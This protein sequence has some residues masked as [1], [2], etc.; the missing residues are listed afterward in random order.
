VLPH[1]LSIETVQQV[2]V[3]AAPFDVRLGSFAGGLVNVVTKSGSNE[4]HGAVFGFV[5]D[6]R[7]VARNVARQRTDFTTRQFGG[8]VSGPIVRDRVHFF[9]NAD[10]QRRVVPDAG[11]FVTDTLGGVRQ[12]RVSYGNALRFQN[13]LSGYGVDGGSLGP[14]DGQLPA[15]DLFGKITLQLGSKSRVELS[16]RLAHADRRDFMDVGQRFDTTAL[17]SVA[18]LSRSSARTSRLIWNAL[19]GN[20]AQNEVI[21]SY[22]R[23]F[24]SCRPNGVLPRIQVAVDSGFLIAGP[25]SVCPTTAVDQS[26]IEVTENLSLGLGGHV[27]TVGSHLGR[28]RFRDP[29]V[30]SS[31]GRWFFPSLDALA[32]GRASHYDRGLPSATRLPG[33]DFHAIELGLYLQDRWAPSVRLTLTAGLRVDLPYLPDPVKT[34][35]PLLAGRGIDTGRLP[36]GHALWSPRLGATYDLGSDGASILRGGAGLFGGPPPYRW[37]G[38]GYRESGD[39]SVVV[40]DGTEVPQF[41]PNAQ[42]A[43]CRSSSG[44]TPRISFFDPGLKLPQ[45][46][47]VALGVDRRLP[48]DVHASVDLLYTRALHQ[49]YLSDANLGVAGGVALSEGGRVLYGV[50]DSTGRATPQWRDASFGEVYQVSDQAGDRSV[51]LSIQARKEL[52]D[53]VALNASYAYSRARDR[54]SLVNFPARANFSNTPLDGPMDDRVLRESYF[55]TPH[56][57]SLTA[58]LALPYRTRFAILYVGASQPPYTYVI[59]GDANADGIGGPGTLPNDIV[60]VPRDARPGGDI[61]LVVLSRGLLT[62]APE[63]EYARL[64]AFIEQQPCLRAQRG[65][66]MARN[67]CRNSWLDLL[68]ARLT[69]AWSMRG[70]QH[71]EIIGD[72]FNASNL[73]NSRWGRHLDTTTDPSLPMLR[74]RGWDTENGRGRYEFLP[75]RRAIIDDAASRW[76]IELGARYQ[77]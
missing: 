6:G 44:V 43:S 21:V 41:T 12:T 67:S 32:Q 71:M 10:L 16:Q 59:T 45:S 72:V 51:S 15:Y 46:L 30:Q 25:N 35:A 13:L 47:K 76:R 38:N 77:F 36:S 3:L 7:L 28:F 26:A 27:L 1:A 18:G 49:I 24:D 63:A 57:V 23:L 65:R 2:Q 52:R 20:R 73:V 50:L 62:T 56:K 55:S 9:A 8:T 29:L 74:L 39:E 60:Y 19:L 37:L 54:M 11:P 22:A 70:E 5:Q 58:T 42:P 69:K 14:T 68:N 66:I 4:L 31:A 17:S 53:V 33:A 34:N 75:M 64:R 40:C 48:G 61:D